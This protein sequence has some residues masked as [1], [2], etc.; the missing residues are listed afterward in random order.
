MPL[1][2]TPLEMEAV[3]FN[4]SLEYCVTKGPEAVKVPY[5]GLIYLIFQPCRSFP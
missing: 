3:M 2:S 4:P 5:V 1:L